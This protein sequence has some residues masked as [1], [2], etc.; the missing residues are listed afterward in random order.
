MPNFLVGFSRN[1]SG[2]VA[3][4]YALIMAIVAT[5]IALAATSLGNAIAAALNNAAL[6]L[7]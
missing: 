6:A 7:R 3:A 1:E 2:S 5:G 4:E